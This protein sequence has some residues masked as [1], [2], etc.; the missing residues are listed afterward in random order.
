MK[1]GSR[2]VFYLRVSKKTVVITT[3]KLLPDVTD[4]FSNDLF[5]EFVSMMKEPL[6]E[7][8]TV[9]ETGEKKI[10]DKELKTIR[11]IEGKKLKVAYAFE[12]DDSRCAALKRK[13][14]VDIQAGGGGYNAFYIYRYNLVA[15]LSLMPMEEILLLE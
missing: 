13:N 5:G 1:V 10:K 14:E 4:V 15:S 7:H 8:M 9:F 11:I 3:L 6:L 2:R 12:I